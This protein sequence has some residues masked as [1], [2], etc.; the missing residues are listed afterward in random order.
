M[1]FMQKGTPEKLMT[2]NEVKISAE[3]GFNTKG[4]WTMLDRNER[5]FR[6]FS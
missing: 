1:K 4:F 2:T 5:K 6:A 3:H